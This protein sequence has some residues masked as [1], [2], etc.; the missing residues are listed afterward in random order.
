MKNIILVFIVFEVFLVTGATGYTQDRVE[1]IIIG[2]TCTGISEIPA[3]WIDSVQSILK[4]HYAHTSHG[5]QLWAGLSYIEAGDS[6]YSTAYEDNNLPEEEGTFC[7]FNGQQ[8]ETYITPELYWATLA[9]MNKTR[10]VLDTNPDINISMWAWCTQL[11]SYSQVQVMGYLDSISV[12]EAEYPG[13]TFV[14][15]TGN[16]Q[17]TGS[18]GYNRYLR[19]EEIRQYCIDNKRVLYDFADLDSWW[20]NPTT[21]LWEQNTYDYGETTV[22]VEHEQFN[23]DEVAHTTVESCIQKGRAV[24]WMTALL[25]GW[26]SVITDSVVIPAMS[27]TLFQNQPNPFNPATKIRYYLP[28]RSRVELNIYDVSGRMVVRLDEGIKDKDFYSVGWNGLDARGGSVA[29]GV[30]FYRLKAGEETITKKMIL[31][32]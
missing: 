18:E 19:N 21:E 23:G 20:Y 16:A 12:L 9:G 26:E 32:R 28:E 6:K 27:L 17:G 10:A 7:I 31:L 25:A 5:G 13:V 8:V 3:A 22:P 11:N 4:L 15:M 1:P 24:W 30:Y 14:Y 2:H 29:S